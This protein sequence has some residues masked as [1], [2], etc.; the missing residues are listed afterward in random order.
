MLGSVCNLAC[1]SYK[2]AHLIMQIF[3]DGWERPLPLK[4]KL[5]QPPLEGRSK[6]LEEMNL[7]H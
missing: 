6:F 1:V 5:E 2:A 7:L 4:L 3:W